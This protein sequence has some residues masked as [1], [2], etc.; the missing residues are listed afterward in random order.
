MIFL[1]RKRNKQLEMRLLNHRTFYKTSTNWH[2][3]EWLEED[4]LILTIHL[5]PVLRVDEYRRK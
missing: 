1:D 2:N 4:D 3:R 5:E